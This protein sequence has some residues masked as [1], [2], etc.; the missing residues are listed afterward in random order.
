MA[1]QDIKSDMK[2]SCFPTSSSTAESDGLDC[3]SVGQ[4]P[5][6]WLKQILAPIDFSAA[7]ANGLR[8]AAA[9]AR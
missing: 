7:S 8:L 5:A 6:I 3:S 4:H 2:P 9:M 1:V